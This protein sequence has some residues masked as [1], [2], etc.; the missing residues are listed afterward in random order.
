MAA[1]KEA[2]TVERY[3]TSA[4]V[5]TIDEQMRAFEQI[6]TNVSQLQLNG[7]GTVQKA[8]AACWLAQG[9]GMHPAIFIQNHYCMEIGGKLLVEPKWEFIVGMLQSRIPGF[10]WETLIETDD[11]AEVRMSDGKSTHTVRYTLADAKRQGLLTKTAWQSNS[12]EMLFKQ[13]VKRCGR[14]IGA[15]ALMDL[16]VGLDGDSMEVGVE[17][18]PNVAAEIEKAIADAPREERDA[19]DVPFEEAPSPSSTS[20]SDTPPTV[21][22]SPSDPDANPLETPKERLARLIK[23]K[24]GPMSGQGMLERATWL[25]NESV[26][27]RTGV[28]PK[29]KPKK[30]GLGPIEAGQA[31]DWLEAQ[32]AKKDSREE[33]AA[34]AEPVPEV[35]DEPPPAEEAAAPEPEPPARA[36][37]RLFEPTKEAAYDVL[38][39]TVFR[40]RKLFAPRQFIKEAP[41]DS[42]IFWFVDQDIFKEAGYT[43][44]VKLQKAG[45]VVADVATL[46]QLR[47]ILEKACDAK[48]RGR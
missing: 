29:E 32:M 3:R 10:T 31:A 1:A 20:P 5:G 30:G 33:P 24:Y 13:A 41:P 7:W 43:G 28:D 35:E 37:S 40:A 2:V 44:S 16:P 47:K 38:M 48:E 19:V 11:C 14:R 15:A 17:E 42:N 34:A 9:A 45:E 27:E 18:A 36:P 23:K 4:L 22:T 46:E 26:K 8:K 6:A 25:Y 21:S 39:D 12:R